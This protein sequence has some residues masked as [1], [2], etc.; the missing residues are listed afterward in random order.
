M[1][2]LRKAA[3]L[4]FANKQDMKGCMTAAEISKYL[5]LSSI[6]DHPWHIQS[7]CALTGEGWVCGFFHISPKCVPP[8]CFLL[9]ILFHFCSD[10]VSGWNN[11]TQML[12]LNYSLTKLPTIFFVT[13]SINGMFHQKRVRTNFWRKF[14][15]CRFSVVVHFLLV[16][17]INW[18]K[19]NV[20]WIKQ[21]MSKKLSLNSQ[22]STRVRLFLIRSHFGRHTSKQ[23]TIKKNAILMYSSFSKNLHLDMVGWGEPIVL[24]MDCP[25]YF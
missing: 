4:I 5:T 17:F 23:W 13:V 22:L 6:K 12:L 14:L 18:E 3:V 9:W 16:S 15:Q 20:T 8:A 25:V 1:Q 11:F 10:G 2:D 24:H 19:T 21:E 7:C